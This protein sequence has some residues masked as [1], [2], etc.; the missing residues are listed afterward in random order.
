MKIRETTIID[1][2]LAATSAQYKDLLEQL[3]RTDWCDAV[4]SVVGSSST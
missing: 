4:L 1:L 3:L 2:T